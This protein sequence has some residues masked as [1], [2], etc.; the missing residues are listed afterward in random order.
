MLADEPRMSLIEISPDT[1]NVQLDLAYATSNNF[2]NP[3]NDLGDVLRPKF[4]I[5]SG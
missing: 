3:N 1:H 5:A 4:N 2:T